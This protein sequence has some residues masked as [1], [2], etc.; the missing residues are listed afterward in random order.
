MSAQVRP[1]FRLSRPPNYA[2]PGDKAAAAA[3]VP[4]A[5]LEATTICGTESYVKDRIDAYRE[6]G[7]THLQIV[8]VPQDGESEASVVGRLKDLVD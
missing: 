2:E 3:A 5:L 7:V 1:N 6:A 4:P 8:P